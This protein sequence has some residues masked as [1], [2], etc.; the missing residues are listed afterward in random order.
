MGLLRLARSETVI[1]TNPERGTCPSCGSGEVTHILFGL[2]ADPGAEPEWVSFGG[3]V[4]DGIPRNRLCESCGHEWTSSIWEGGVDDCPIVR[5]PVR[6]LGEAGAAFALLP[7]PELQA[8]GNSMPVDCEFLSPDRLVRYLARPV[9]VE[10]VE[11]LADF[12]MRGA[13]DPIPEQSVPTVEDES[14]GLAVLINQSAPLSVALEV[15]IVTTTEE[16]VPERDGVAFDVPRA[17]LIK[18]A[19]ELSGWLA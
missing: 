2:P 7:V 12:F 4:I 9:T 8:N 19:H 10:L 16:G 1:A 11:K 5:L 6:L 13:S 14:S 17:A 15:A 3:C 18:A